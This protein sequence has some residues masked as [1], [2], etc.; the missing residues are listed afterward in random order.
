MPKFQPVRGMRD[1]LH[2]EAEMMTFVMSKARETANLF[3]YN[4]V[5][6]PVIEPYE[7][8]AAKSGEEIRQ[9]SLTFEPV[10]RVNNNP[11]LTPFFVKY[12][13]NLR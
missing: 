8:L 1:L 3:G 4:E 9:H 7:L 13:L 5:I 2:D 12:T 11:Q 6:T 10:C